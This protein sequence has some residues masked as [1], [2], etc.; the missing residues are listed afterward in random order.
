M[1]SQLEKIQ[2]ARLK[3][4]IIIEEKNEILNS[5]FSGEA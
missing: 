4:D 2:Q 1:R 5:W 3:L